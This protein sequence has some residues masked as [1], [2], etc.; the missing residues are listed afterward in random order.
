M[1]ELAIKREL[2]E[3]T[4]RETVWCHMNGAVECFS[5]HVTKHGEVILTDHSDY[6]KIYSVESLDFHRA[7]EKSGDD[8]LLDGIKQLIQNYAKASAAYVAADV[9]GQVRCP[10]SQKT[11][12]NT[13]IKEYNAC[14]DATKELLR[15]V[16][17]AAGFPNTKIIL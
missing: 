2:N 6:A 3:D 5:L 1:K 14:S 16:L 8:M 12:L 4:R 10:D 13:S 17:D 9:K 11:T 7:L 15:A